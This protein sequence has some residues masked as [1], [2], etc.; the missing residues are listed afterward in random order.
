MSD[1]FDKARIHSDEWFAEAFK[2][3]GAK[4]APEWMLQAARHICRSY[5]IQ[6]QADPAYIVSTLQTYLAD[7]EPQ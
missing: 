3:S 4:D 5:N 1:R 2:L 7:S 6:G